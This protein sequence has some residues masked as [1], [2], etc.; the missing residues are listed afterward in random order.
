MGIYILLMAAGL[1]ICFGGIY[2]RRACSAILGFIWGILGALLIALFTVGIWEIGEE[3]TVAAIFIS[4]L[5]FSVLSAI[6][7]RLSVA[8]NGFLSTFSIALIFV[9]LSGDRDSSNAAIVIACLAGLVAAVI[10]FFVYDYLFVIITAFSGS[11]VAS[12]SGMC[13]IKKYD[14]DDVISEILWYGIDDVVA[15]I[16]TSTVIIGILGMIVQLIRLHTLASRKSADGTVQIKGLNNIDFSIFTQ[17]IEKIRNSSAVRELKNEKLSILLIILGFVISPLTYYRTHFDVPLLDHISNISYYYLLPIAFS[18]VIYFVYNKKLSTVIVACFPRIIAILYETI[19]IYH[20]FSKSII[21]DILE[22]VLLVFICLLLKKFVRND[23][24]YLCSVL[25]F[26]VNHYLILDWLNSRRI[27]WSLYKSDILPIV[28]MTLALALLVYAKTKISILDFP[29]F[30][31]EKAGKKI[32]NAKAFWITSACIVC[33]I[34]IISTAFVTISTHLE[35]KATLER[36]QEIESSH[37]NASDGFEDSSYANR[38]EGTTESAGTVQHDEPIDS[39][40][41]SPIYTIIY[42]DSDV[43]YNIQFV[44]NCW[45]DTHDNVLWDKENNLTG[46]DGTILADIKTLTDS[47]TGNRLQYLN[48]YE[49]DTE[50]YSI[51]LECH[52][53]SDPFLVVGYDGTLTIIKDNK[54]LSSEEAYNYERRSYTG[55]YFCGICEINNGKLGDYVL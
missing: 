15:P 20:Y 9:L 32:V 47:E 30:I 23:I 34:F 25:I 16:I 50:Y 6:F 7:Y 51:S 4:G 37:S 31:N 18:V 42:E 41:K 14:V 1:L 43:E 54:V 46:D 17:L 26:V 21:Y 48:I 11:F 10:S 39:E 24:K 2:L 13:L 29:R 5:V 12:V 19:A 8:V 52:D 49:V 3:K 27:Y 22:V 40:S 33:G 36:Y 45:S 55:A 35:N 53:E 28:I 38:A 44:V